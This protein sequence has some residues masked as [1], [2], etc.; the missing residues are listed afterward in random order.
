MR[1]VIFSRD[2]DAFQLHVAGETERD[3]RFV[4]IFDN[5]K[6][7]SQRDR[8]N[9]DSVTD[10]KKSE[11]LTREEKWFTERQKKRVEPESIEGKH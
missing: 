2:D 11:T 7:K 8:E 1:L 4:V 5:N 9:Q 3:D 10:K 6:V